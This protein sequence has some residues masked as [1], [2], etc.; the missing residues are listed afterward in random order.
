MNTNTNTNKI[1]IDEGAMQQLCALL[2][3][4]F[5]KD[6][7]YDVEQMAD[8]EKSLKIVVT[9]KQGDPSEFTLVNAVPHRQLSSRAVKISRTIDIGSTILS[10]AALGFQVAILIVNGVISDDTSSSSSENSSIANELV[11]WMSI[12][13]MALSLIASS[14]NQVLDK[15]KK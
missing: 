2:Q 10:I 6:E 14:K 15:F 9:A 12:V 7:G 13:T 3:T 11:K 5:Q 1:V 8:C 4:K